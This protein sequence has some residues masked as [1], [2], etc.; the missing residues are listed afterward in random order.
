MQSRLRRT[1]E[2]ITIISIYS[3]VLWQYPQNNNNMKI[4][5]PFSNAIRRLSRSREVQVQRRRRNG[6]TWPP[7]LLQLFLWLIIPILASITAFL[8]IPLHTLYAPLVS[9]TG[10]IWLLLQIILLTSIDPAVSNLRKNQPPAY[11]DGTKHEHV[12]ENLFCNICLINNLIIDSFPAIQ[13]VNIVGNVTNAFQDSII[14]ANGL[15]IASVR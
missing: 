4:C 12:I 3:K 8:L 10:T 2:E 14:T 9:F 5:L 6:W 11:F 13:A 1:M 7:S 15:T